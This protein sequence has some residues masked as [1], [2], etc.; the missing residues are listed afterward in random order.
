MKSSVSL[1]LVIAFKKAMFTSNCRCENLASPQ[2]AKLIKTFA[3]I[4]LQQSTEPHFIALLALKARICGTRS[5]IR[6]IFFIE[7]CMFVGTIVVI[8]IA[9]FSWLQKFLKLLLYVGLSGGFCSTFNTCVNFNALVMLVR[10]CFRPLPLLNWK[11]ISLFG[12]RT[13]HFWLTNC[14]RYSDT[15]FVVKKLMKTD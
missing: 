10:W 13:A 1:V 2:M 7:V 8:T 6:T 9:E 14:L 15:S 12:K 11:V 5:V 4:V 3:F